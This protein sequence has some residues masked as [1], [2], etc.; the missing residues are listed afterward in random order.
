[1]IV[2]LGAEKE[3]YKYDNVMSLQQPKF[4][5]KLIENNFLVIYFVWSKFCY[6]LWFIKFRPECHGGGCGA[7]IMSNGPRVAV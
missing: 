4:M 3:F 1:M 5:V 2:S 7:T 6:K